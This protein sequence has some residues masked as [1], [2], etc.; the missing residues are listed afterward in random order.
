MRRRKLSDELRADFIA[1]GLVAPAVL[2]AGLW[3]LHLAGRL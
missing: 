1:W 3:V 2:I